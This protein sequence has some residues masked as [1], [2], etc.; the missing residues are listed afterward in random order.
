MSKLSKDIGIAPIRLSNLKHR[1]CGLAERYLLELEFAIPQHE[2]TPKGVLY[3]DWI[4]WLRTNVTAPA[5][6]L[7]ESVSGGNIS[8]WSGFPNLHQLLPRPYPA[9]S[10]IGR[11]L[12][13][14]T[15][16]STAFEEALKL[17]SSQRSG[18]IKSAGRPI[19]D[20]KYS[21]A[22]DLLE[23]YVL[24]TRKKPALISEKRNDTSRRQVTRGDVLNFI[25]LTA[26]PI[27]ND[28][29]VDML[30]ETRTAIRKLKAASRQ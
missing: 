4:K 29:E 5:K 27:L 15:A 22:F 9:L 20:L 23:I 28:P 3:K 13:Q 12:Q 26:R 21:L 11:E 25:R 2:A 30:D 17:H 19:T 8:W 24:V 14:L 16:W 1:L 7:S 10:S 6:L 18:N